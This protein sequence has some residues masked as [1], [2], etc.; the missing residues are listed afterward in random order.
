MK[1]DDLLQRLADYRDGSLTSTLCD[2]ID[3]HLSECPP[4]AELDRDLRD[5]Q[6]M[7]RESPQPCLPEVARKRIEELLRSRGPKRDA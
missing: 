7:C 3:R 4:C 1:C 6:R 2:E 5:L